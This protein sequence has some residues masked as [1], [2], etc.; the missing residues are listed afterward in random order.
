MTKESYEETMRRQVLEMPR[1]RVVCERHWMYG[2]DHYVVGLVWN[3][4]LDAEPGEFAYR[5]RW[6]LHIKFRMNLER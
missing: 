4:N 3:R 6:L 5:R 2:P 1:I